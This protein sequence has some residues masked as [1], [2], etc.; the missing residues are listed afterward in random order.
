LVLFS[1]WLAF[2]SLRQASITGHK[3]ILEDNI[4]AIVLQ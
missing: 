4:M 3:I 2:V 1:C